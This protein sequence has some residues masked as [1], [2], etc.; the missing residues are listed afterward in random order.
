MK[1]TAFIAAACMASIAANADDW[2]APYLDVQA[3]VAMIDL[4]LFENAWSYDIEVGYRFNKYFGISYNFADFGSAEI[5]TSTKPTANTSAHYPS[6]SLYWPVNNGF[7]VYVT[8]GYAEWES[9]LEIDG[10]RAG[11]QDGADSVI[12][13][14]GLVAISNNMTVGAEFKRF[15]LG[16]DV[17]MDTYQLAFRYSF[18]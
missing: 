2:T 18:Y 13:Y 8:A 15:D 6:V 9:E 17:D 16:G 1:R 5:D 12:G 11:K 10:E 7:D 4:P 3:G 14:G